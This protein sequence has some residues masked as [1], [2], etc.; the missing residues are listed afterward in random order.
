MKLTKKNNGRKRTKYKKKGITKLGLR[1][2]KAKG[3]VKTEKNTMGEN[4]METKTWE[5]NKK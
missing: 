1:T 4:K 3:E 2:K 5:K